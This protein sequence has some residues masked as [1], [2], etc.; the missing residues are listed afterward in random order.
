MLRQ[1]CATKLSRFVNATGE[2]SVGMYVR[3][4]VG[5][6][7]SMFAYEGRQHT[8]MLTWFNIHTHGRQRGKDGHT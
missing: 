6:C 2:F 7:V 4:Q 5:W 8:C 1:K 3:A